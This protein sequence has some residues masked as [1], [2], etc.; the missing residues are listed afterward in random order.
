M[1]TPVP[2]ELNEAEQ[3][4]MGPR[5]DSVSGPNNSF[6]SPLWLERA[7]HKGDEMSLYRPKKEQKSEQKGIH[8]IID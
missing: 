6:D 1:P 3:R 7:K 5:K 4:G 8:H 2:T